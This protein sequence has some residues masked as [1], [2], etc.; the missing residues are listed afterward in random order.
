MF[1]LGEALTELL[2]AQTVP[3]GVLSRLEV[4]VACHD[5]SKRG[6]VGSLSPVNVKTQRF[7]LALV[8]PCQ[9]RATC[10]KHL[11]EPRLAAELVIDVHQ[12]LHLFH[13]LVRAPDLGVL[14][15][16]QVVE[17]FGHLLY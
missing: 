9:E 14:D 10:D 13:A 17:E 5:L 16:D 3:D 4:K 7:L 11:V 12:V 6:E 1:Q 2:C 15:Q 8:V